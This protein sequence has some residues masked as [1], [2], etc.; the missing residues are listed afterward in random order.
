[1][2]EFLLNAKVVQSTPIGKGVTHPWRL[3]LSDGTMTHDAAF[4]TVDERLMT[5]RFDNGKAEMNFVDSYH[6]NI[7]A[8]QIAEMPISMR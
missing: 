8:C 5:K 4:E 7:A 2:R 1:M 6:Y 3:T